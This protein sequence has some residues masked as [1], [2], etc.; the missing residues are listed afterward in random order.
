MRSFRCLLAA[1]AALTAVGAGSSSAAPPL[2][3]YG[4]PTIAPDAYLCITQFTPENAVPGVGVPMVCAGQCYGPTPILPDS[5]P[6]NTVIVFTLGGEEGRVGVVSKPVVPVPNGGECGG[7]PIAP[8]E[9]SPVVCAHRYQSP[10]NDES[11]IV[12]GT[13]AGTDC[14]TYRIPQSVLADLVE[15]IRERLGDCAPRSAICLG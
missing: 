2:G 11:Y 4:A 1:A 10:Y 12:V 9:T 14:S 6:T 7:D 5:S 3:C 8:R 15:A 13:C